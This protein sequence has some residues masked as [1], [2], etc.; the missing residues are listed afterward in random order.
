MSWNT[1]IPKFRRFVLQNFPFIEE[2]FDALTDYELICK[3]IE[4]LNKV[5]TS[6]NEVVSELESFE[7]NITNNFNNLV[8]LFNELKS[9][10]ENYFDNLDVQ[11]EINNKLDAMADD[12]TLQEIV[13]QYLNATA[14]WCFDNVESMKSS[15]NLIDGSFAQ[16]LGY[17]EK[18]DH[19][20]ATYKIR[21]MTNSDVVDNATII[22]IGSGTLIAE[23]IVGAKVNV[24]Q[25][26]AYGD[27]V[28]DDSAAIQK[29]VSYINAKMILFEQ[30]NPNPDWHRWFSTSYTLYFPSLQYLISERIEFNGSRY[31]NIEGNKSIITSDVNMNDPVFYFDGANGTK[32]QISG[33]I[34]KE[35]KNAIEYDS[36]NNDLSKVMIKN[37]DFVGVREY[38]IKYN[39]RSSMLKIENCNFSWCFKILYNIKC[40]CV[41]FT[42]CWF[43]EYESDQDD[44]VSFIILWGENKFINCHFIP[45]GNYNPTIDQSTLSNL[46]W[47]QAGD[48]ETASA[49]NPGL[50]FDRCRVSAETNSKTMVNWKVIPNTG[51]SPTD[52]YIK[53]LNC[54]ALAC[55]RGKTVIRAWHVPQQVIF[56]NCEISNEDA[57]FITFVDGLDVNTDISTYFNGANRRYYV[58]N[59]GFK[60]VKTQTETAWKRIPK[61]IAPFIRYTDQDVR[62]PITAS[63]K[64]ATFNFGDTT[65]STPGFFSKIFLVKGYVTLINGVAGLSSFTGLLLF[66]AVNTTVETNSSIRVKYVPIAQYAGGTNNSTQQTIEIVPTFNDTNSSVITMSGH[67]DLSVKLTITNTI[68]DAIDNYITIK[69]L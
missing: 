42:N 50:L 22:P 55:V 51:N 43:S 37:C 26:G 45:N 62:I 29:A 59:Y 32:S 3:V 67:N 11:E 17:Y 16:T 27:G 30:S 25:F 68:F 8:N 14:I 33:F 9:Y 7:T 34:F 12:G 54:Y 44:Y 19:G 23:L 38:A 41:E 13:G 57:T 39:N 64:T 69:E 65:L 47:I 46:A 35:M 63:D 6:Q 20:S 24:N 36:T 18:G 40:D 52:T 15:T 66:D 4:Y 53:F 49:N 58:F 21:E 5:I 1:H 28:H 61:E 56:E 31:Y 2:D 48:N 10:V 60:N